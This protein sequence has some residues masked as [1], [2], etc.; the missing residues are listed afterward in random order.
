MLSEKSSFKNIYKHIPTVPLNC[1]IIFPI[2]QQFTF[3][4]LAE[5]FRS[6]FTFTTL[7]VNGCEMKSSLL[8]GDAQ[9]QCQ[10]PKLSEL[11]QDH[12]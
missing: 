8:G 1:G 5:D 3:Q 4:V 12:N 9:R 2:D 11:P 6:H 10:K 7:H